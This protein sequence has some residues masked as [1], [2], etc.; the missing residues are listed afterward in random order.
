M[1]IPGPY[2]PSP[3]PTHITILGWSGG[4]TPQMA[5]QPEEDSGIQ[6]EV[7]FSHLYFLVKLT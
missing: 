7:W 6:T 1:T 3:I 2:F 4:S 5:A